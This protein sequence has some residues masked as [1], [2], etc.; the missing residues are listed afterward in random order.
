MATIDSLGTSISTLPSQEF[1]T[2]IMGIRA[3][4]R[5]KPPPR[6][7][8]P[9]KTKRRPNAKAPRQQDLFA[10]AGNM[11]NDQKAALA[12]KLMNL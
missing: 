4:R 9:A 11:T 6:R 2:L 10:L 3:H 8:A 12:A 7:K 5:T 1:Y